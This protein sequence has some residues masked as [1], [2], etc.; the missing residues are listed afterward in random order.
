M[1]RW[2]NDTKI[3][4]ITIL[5][6]LLIGISM[7]FF[8]T[9]GNY[10]EAAEKDRSRLGNRPSQMSPE[11]ERTAGNIL[12]RN[13]DQSRFSHNF[14]GFSKIVDSEA[15]IYIRQVFIG[16]TWHDNEREVIVLDDAN[17]MIEFRIQSYT[18][19]SWDNVE[20]DV[21]S[22]DGDASLPSIATNQVW[23]E[24]EW[25]NTEREFLSFD[26]SGRLLDIIYE[27]WQN[28]DW[29]SE[30]RN[31]FSYTSE[32]R[33]SEI[34]IYFWS[35][36][37]EPDYRLTWTYDSEQNEIELLE[38]VYDADEWRSEFRI[39][40]EYENGNRIIEL[41]QDY[42]VPDDEWTN[43]FRRLYE[44][45]NGNN[46]V[47]TSQLY[48]DSDEEWFNFNRALYTYDGAGNQTEL[49]SQLWNQVAEEWINSSRTQ[50]EYT[51][52][53]DVSLRLYSSWAGVEWIFSRRVTF[54]YSNDGD[55]LIETEEEWTGSEWEYTVR[56]LYG[57]GEPTSVA[58]DPELPVQFELMQNYPNPFNPTTTIRFTIPEQTSVNLVVYDLLGRTVE[59]LIT[60]S[61]QPG[62]Y[63]HFFDASRLASGV[64]VYQLKAGQYVETRRLVL[65]K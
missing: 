8:S 11:M 47:R 3:R 61:L 32:G 55:L 31:T 1:N 46:T 5:F 19:D 23:M 51:P 13:Y 63:S 34:V 64:Y 2:Y 42:N 30:E 4:Y 14:M 41:Y 24:E 16:G 21:Y 17:R 43:S 49:I 7:T 50:S 59:I 52:Q 28:D 65:M 53:G 45:E 12:I 38:E 40:S 57:S 39:L 22:Y 18:L 9:T 37:W 48:D 6:Y 29:I 27:L 35:G 33:T 36:E 44:Y 15:V 58:G 60:E 10:L 20:R 25:I 56:H 62:E 54:Q 26:N